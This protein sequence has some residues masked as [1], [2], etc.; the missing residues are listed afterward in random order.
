M[1][2]LVLLEVSVKQ[3]LLTSQRL[4]GVYTDLALLAAA[5][6]KAPAFAEAFSV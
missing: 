4:W 6:E 5:K 3:I 1:S 2:L